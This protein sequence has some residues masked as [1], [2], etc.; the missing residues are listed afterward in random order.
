MG[1]KETKDDRER[2]I[3]TQEAEEEA[4][5]NIS[6]RPEKMEHFVGQQHTVEN[7]KIAI[8]AAKKRKESLEHILL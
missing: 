8:K 2:L 4:I 5:F 3:T 1:K 6:L 7:V